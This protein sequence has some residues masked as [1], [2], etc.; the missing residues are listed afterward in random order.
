MESSFL[1]MNHAHIQHIIWGL[2]DIHPSH[3]LGFLLHLAVKSTYG[4]IGNLVSSQARLK[5]DI[6]QKQSAAKAVITRG[7]A[8]KKSTPLFRK[9][10]N[11]IGNLIG[12]HIL[13]NLIGSL[14][15]SILQ[16]WH[17]NHFPSFDLRCKFSICHS[18]RWTWFAFFLRE[19]GLK[20]EYGILMHRGLHSGHPFWGSL[21]DHS[22]CP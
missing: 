2:W 19:Y 13:G 21:C 18:S 16:I 15:H 9:I 6:R 1:I 17:H 22:N 5:N 3:L 4:L 20:L 12:S 8:L 10:G 7:W 14:A 11:L